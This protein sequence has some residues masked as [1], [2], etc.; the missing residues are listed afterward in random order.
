MGVESEDDQYRL[1]D[2]H[3]VCRDG[4]EWRCRVCGFTDNNKAT[5]ENCHPD[6]QLNRERDTSVTESESGHTGFVIPPQLCATA[7]E[8]LGEIQTAVRGVNAA[9]V[10]PATASILDRRLPASMNQTRAFQVFTHLVWLQQCQALPE[11]PIRTNACAADTVTIREFCNATD[12]FEGT[13]TE[14]QIRNSDLLERKR[15]YRAKVLSVTSDFFL[16]SSVADVGFASLWEWETTLFTPWSETEFQTTALFTESTTHNTVVRESRNWLATHPEIDWACAPHTMGAP[17]GTQEGPLPP[18]WADKEPPEPPSGPV[19]MFDFAGIT[20]QPRPKVTVIGCVIGAEPVEEVFARI[21]RIRETTATALV[22]VRNRN[23]I[24]RLIDS[25]DTEG[26]F[27]T[28][29][30]PIDDTIEYYTRRPSIQAVNEEFTDR[31]PQ[32][33]HVR[34]VTAKQL[35]DDIVTPVDVLPDLVQTRSATER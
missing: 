1:T 23:S 5:V 17:R 3:H 21:K 28:P 19:W 30:A 10:L 32:L 29:A 13:V 31:V 2:Y 14:A 25:G 11:Y 12:A 26:W 18:P 34:F 27:E 6:A 4:S 9:S 24:H 33:D 16:R 20:E 8:L 22:V 35:I 15:I 7:R